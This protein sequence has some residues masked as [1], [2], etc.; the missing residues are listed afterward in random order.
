MASEERLLSR[1]KSSVSESNLVRPQCL[2]ILMIITENL[3]RTRSQSMSYPRSRGWRVTDRKT[4][5]KAL[6]SC[7]CWRQ[8]KFKHRVQN[9]SVKT[10]WSSKQV[11]LS[12][13]ERCKMDTLIRISKARDVVFYGKNWEKNNHVFRMFDVYRVWDF[14][15]S[16][17]P[18]W[19]HLHFKHVD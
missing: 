12:F 16:W 4:W 19:R 3:T 15:S 1:K 5:L 11:S 17:G 13:L 2:Y 18:L 7:K 8:Q 9:R 14:S 6:P 10:V